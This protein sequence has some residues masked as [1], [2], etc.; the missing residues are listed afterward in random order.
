MVQVADEAGKTVTRSFLTK[1]DAL[2]FFL[3]MR[4]NRARLRAT[5]EPLRVPKEFGSFVDAW[6][7]KRKAQY[8]ESTTSG[9]MSKLRLTWKPLFKGRDLHTITT[10]EL[11]TRLDLLITE[12]DLSPATHNR[13]R[14]LLSGIFEAARLD[15]TVPVNPVLDIKQRE[16]T[17]AAQPYWLGAEQGALYVGEAYREGLVWGTLATL[18]FWGG[19]RISEALALKWSDVLWEF[20]SM[21]VSR[22]RETGTGRFHDR[23]KGQGR[24]GHYS[25]LLLPVV[26]EALK[27]WREVTRLAGP[28][29]FIFVLGRRPIT[30]WQYERLHGIFVERAALPRITIHGLR[31]TYASLAQMKGF[32]R[33]DI[34]GL[35]GHESIQTTERYTH[36]DYRDLAEKAKRFGFG[37]AAAMIPAQQEPSQAGGS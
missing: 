26:A 34:Q 7:A 28:S 35:L 8:P 29:D 1:D 21:R 31:H 23:T 33:E 15:K 25:L 2:E 12:D 18:L 19:P 10:K 13:H 36:V 22:I 16:E 5:L 3:L 37:V 11:K 9:E 27:R 4:Q 32:R 24:G 17:P 14:A 30:Y 6:M 20:A